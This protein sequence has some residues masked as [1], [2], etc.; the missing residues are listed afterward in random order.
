MTKAERLAHIKALMD[1]RKSGKISDPAV[2]VGLVIIESA[3]RDGRCSLS[4][5]DIGARAGIRRIP[6]ISARLTELRKAE[7]MAMEWS[8]R[9]NSYALPMLDNITPSR[10]THNKNRSASTR[11]IKGK[12]DGTAPGK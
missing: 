11:N 12:T 5:V 3:G 9:L 7:F 2:T 10:A 1:L 4:R 8:C 6:T